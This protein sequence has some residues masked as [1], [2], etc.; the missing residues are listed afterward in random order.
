M[1]IKHTKKWQFVFNFY[2]DPY[3][4]FPAKVLDIWFIKIKKYPQEVEWQWDKS[5]YQGFL[6]STIIRRPKLMLRWEFFLDI[7]INN[8]STRLWIKKI[9]WLWDKPEIQNLQEESVEDMVK[10]SIPSQDEVQ[11]PMDEVQNLEKKRKF[12]NIM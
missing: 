6:L 8:K 11:V 10:R 4:Y 3:R 9:L 7:Y 1:A 12:K 5:S 2:Q